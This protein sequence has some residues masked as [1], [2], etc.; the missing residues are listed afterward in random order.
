MHPV[1]GMEHPSC[2]PQSH[3]Y[4][5][6][7]PYLGGLCVPAR[8]CVGL[9]HTKDHRRF[10]PKLVPKRAQL[11]QHDEQA[12]LASDSTEICLQLRRDWGDAGAAGGDVYL[13]LQLGA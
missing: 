13:S 6:P 12:G 1:H 11:P 4:D 8:H 5:H 10:L 2:I 9:L 3:H 7:L